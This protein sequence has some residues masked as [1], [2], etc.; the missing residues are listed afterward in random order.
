M[1]LSKHKLSQH[2]NIKETILLLYT[3]KVIT[4]EMYYCVYT[5]SH[6]SH[7]N[8]LSKWVFMCLAS[9]PFATPV[10]QSCTFQLCG[11]FQCASS[12]YMLCGTFF[13]KCYSWTRFLG[14]IPCCACWNEVDCWILFHNRHIDLECSSLKVRVTT[15]EFNNIQNSEYF[16]FLTDSKPPSYP[17]SLRYFL[18]FLQFPGRC[19]APLEIV[20]FIGPRVEPVCTI[21]CLSNWNWSH[22]WYKLGPINV[23]SPQWWRYACTG[24][25]LKWIPFHIF[26]RWNI[27]CFIL[28]VPI[29]GKRSYEQN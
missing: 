25:K 11:H 14:G 26:H 15:E 5:F 28:S 18:L 17:N 13:H 21:S 3:A 10:S 16:R 7:S 9:T 1:L 22:N 29:Y 27:F 20:F 12:K 23:F 24:L 8:L 2:N 4:V 19:E 6:F